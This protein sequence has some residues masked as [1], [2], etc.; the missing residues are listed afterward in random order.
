M[1]FALLGGLLFTARTFRLTREGP[2]TDRYTKAV[3]QG[4]R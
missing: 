2:L 1:S 3:E 4:R